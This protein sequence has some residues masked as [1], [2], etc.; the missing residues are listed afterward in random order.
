M[1]SVFEKY[2]G[3]FP[4]MDSL[5]LEKMAVLLNTHQLALHV[6]IFTLTVLH[7]HSGVQYKTQVIAKHI[8]EDSSGRTSSRFSLAPN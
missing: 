5:Y 7:M 4:E 8:V 3:D 1:V 6:R 2:N